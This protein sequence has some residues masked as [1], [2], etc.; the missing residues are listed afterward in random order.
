MWTVPPDAPANSAPRRTARPPASKSAAPTT[1]L[2]NMSHGCARHHRQSAA[3]AER[4]RPFSACGGRDANH[5]SFRRHHHWDVGGSGQLLPDVATQPAVR[6]AVPV[7]TYDDQ[8]SPERPRCLGNSAHEPLVAHTSSGP[9]H[10][11]L[12]CYLATPSLQ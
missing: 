4:D 12:I 10:R 5:S 1:T 3:W 2:S 7:E 6:Q 9:A 11:E 8:V